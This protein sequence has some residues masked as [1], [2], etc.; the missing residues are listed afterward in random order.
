MEIVAWV[1]TE[2]MYISVLLLALQCTFSIHMLSDIA[3]LNL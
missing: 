1:C 3:P 2:D